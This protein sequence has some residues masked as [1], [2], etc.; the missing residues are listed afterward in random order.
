MTRK[1]FILLLSLV[2]LF[3]A[4]CGRVEEPSGGD[5]VLTFRVG[6]PATKANTPGDG[7]VAD[8][9]GIYCTKVGDEVTP[10][11]VIFIFN[12]DGTLRK[13]YPTDGVL[14][15]SDYDSGHA[16]TLSISFGSSGWEDGAYEVFALAN[17]AGAGGNLDIPNLSSILT[18]SDLQ[19]LQMGISSGTAP[20]V[21]DRMPL[22][23]SGT[24]HVAKG[25]YE[26]YN[27]LVELE[28][29]RCFAK[30]QLT[31]RNLTGVLLTL[32][33]C[34]VKFKD[35]N[36]KKAWLFPR[37][38]DFVTLGDTNPS[39]SKD[40]N[41]GDYTTVAANISTANLTNIP[42]TDDL[43]TDDDERDRVAF[44]SPILFFPSIAPKQT[45]PSAGNRY[46]C[47][48][49]FNVGNA[50]K[51]FNDLPI[52]DEFTQDIP[53]LKR[54]QYLQI[55][56]TIGKGTNV[57]FNFFVKNWEEHNESVTFN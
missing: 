41:Y 28:M 26:K 34:S 36:T 10:D 32:T 54:N 1:E 51:N 47:N 16:T 23:A 17:I 15:E 33:N 50:T 20:Q 42:S 31:F 2:L 44:V 22:S 7:D 9:G 38:P 43:L 14:T 27:G 5:V 11:L 56:T 49:S 19:N 18:I 55:L 53:V 29:L 25:L 48:I 52:H 40:D 24:L 57:S 8:G 12:E 4:A 39:D 13:R 21:G 35:M 3:V 46:L 37:E 6:E 45:V 30:V